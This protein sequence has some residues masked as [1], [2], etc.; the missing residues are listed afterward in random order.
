MVWKETQKSH[1]IEDFKAKEDTQHLEAYSATDGGG[2]VQPY[3]I[4]T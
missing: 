1:L 4:Y 3:D 2:K